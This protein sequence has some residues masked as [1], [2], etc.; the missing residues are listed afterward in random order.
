MASKSKEDELS[1][2]EKVALKKTIEAF[3]SIGSLK[4]DLVR[5][6]KSSKGL[7]E[8]LEA[9]SKISRRLTK[10]G[11]DALAIK[12]LLPELSYIEKIRV[13]NILSP[14]DLS[15]EHASIELEEGAAD[16]DSYGEAMAILR[17]NIDKKLSLFEDLDAI[18][19]ESLFDFGSW[20]YAFLPKEI[21][22]II[23]QLYDIKD[24]KNTVKKDALEAIGENVFGNSF[25]KT[26][27]VFENDKVGKVT[28]STNLADIYGA[29]I[30]KIKRH[31]SKIID[32]R[33]SVA[34][35]SALESYVDLSPLYNLKD[36]SIYYR[37][38]PPDSFIPVTVPGN[39][40][41][42]VGGILV[43]GD[44]G[45]PINNISDSRFFEALSISKT[46]NEF[47]DMLKVLTGGRSLEDDSRSEME[48]MRSIFRNQL[49]EKI[50]SLLKAETGET[51]L[52]NTIQDDYIISAIMA[53]VMSKKEVKLVYLPPWAFSYI[54]FNR[55][56]NGIGISLMEKNKMLVAIRVRL[57][58]SE[59]M[60]GLRNATPSTVIG[61]TLDD[62]ED[63]PNEIINLVV[64]EAVR[65]LP[66][67]LDTYSFNP[68]EI[69][70]SLKRSSVRLKI[71]GGSSLPQ[72]KVEM[73]EEKRENLVPDS[74]IIERVYKKFCLGFGVPAEFVD[75]ALQGDFAVG[76]VMSSSIFSRTNS[77]DQKSL[78]KCLTDLIRKF[79]IADNETYD[80]IK[81]K[82][83]EAKIADFTN[84]VVFSLPKADS[85]AYRDNLTSFNE[86]KDLIT[87]ISEV[88][89]TEDSFSAVGDAMTVKP[90]VTALRT[91]FIQS[92]MRTFV[93]SKNILPDFDMEN[94][95]FIETTLKS[96]Y[97]DLDST[98]K[99][100]LDMNETVKKMVNQAN[101][102]AA[103]LEAELAPKVEEGEAAPDFNSEPP[104][105]GVE[106]PPVEG[107]EPPPADGE[108][109]L[110]LPPEEG[111]GDNTSGEASVTP[112]P[113]T[114]EPTLDEPPVGDEPAVAP[115]GE[116]TPPAQDG[117]E[118][119]VDE[120]P[121]GDEPTDNEA[122]TL[123]EPP[124]GDPDFEDGP[125]IDAPPV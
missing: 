67:L 49:N 95:E 48:V 122:P 63:D 77:M 55:D 124:T 6:N 72:T 24:K 82:V 96:I 13:S 41:S 42:Y 119:L 87:A 62:A 12:E 66:D 52:D 57:F 75:R 98:I 97:S 45:E 115:T 120:P 112:P 64:T 17:D 91:N 76:T 18:V 86:Y 22:P 53:R 70:S 28:L 40:D 90:I 7:G 118:P 71:D 27:V 32:P 103:K 38:L 5:E 54:T 14:N 43:L 44:D 79:I 69:I 107:T 47:K 46:N 60:A 94:K 2:S 8:R 3:R 4:D 20:T 78:E 84:S 39:R 21:G 29:E 121:V 113:G 16:H 31:V 65:W 34:E 61:L 23:N 110:D 88:F 74:D 93:R 114:D 108:P 9:I 83:G 35:R 116:E 56:Q 36:S 51:N 80:A 33:T 30:K 104:V 106:P 1:T 25:G 15:V 58:F 50:G 26:A 105:E 85:P 111:A 19:R 117:E 11:V 101:E 89:F 73:S 37:K 99:F 59:I 102:A 10:V 92:K 81:A 123:D 68:D 100:S 125:L 109:A